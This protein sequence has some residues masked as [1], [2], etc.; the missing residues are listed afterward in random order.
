MLAMDTSTPAITVAL[1]DGRDV[2]V[3]ATVIDRR[4]HTELLM[5]QVVRALSEAGADRRDITDIAVGVGPGPFT[6]LR[7]GLS[8]GRVMGA[9]LGVPVVGVCSLDVLALGVGEVDVDFV[10]ATDA[11]RR[12]VYWARYDPSRRRLTDPSVDAPAVL[13]SDL[14]GA[15]AGPRLYPDVFAGALDPE[16]PSAGLLAAG[17]VHGSVEVLPPEPLYLRHADVTMPGKRKSVLT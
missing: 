12:E 16:F 11:R 13:P 2:V 5:P 7:V 9:A 14:P 10:V 6:G 3:E 8:A 1:H 17:I 15:G 4:Q